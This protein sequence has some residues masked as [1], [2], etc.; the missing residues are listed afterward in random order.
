MSAAQGLSCGWFGEYTELS[1]WESG[2]GTDP[3]ETA[4]WRTALGAASRYGG[5]FD[6]MEAQKMYDR[7]MSSSIR[8]GECVAIVVPFE[9][10]P[11][12]FR[13]PGQP[14]KS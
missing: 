4:A 8:A 10:E 12:G 5:A 6:Q 11:A 2:V 3:V 14:E 1:V 9:T 13:L 7:A